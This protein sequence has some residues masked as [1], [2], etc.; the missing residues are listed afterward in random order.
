MSTRCAF[1]VAMSRAWPKEKVAFMSC[2]VFSLHDMCG[3]MLLQMSAVTG[4]VVI[5]HLSVLAESY[6]SYLQHQQ[7]LRH[8][9][10]NNIMRR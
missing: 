10:Q 5:L 4:L 9:Y 2:F 8:L 6:L 1:V 7:H 3:V